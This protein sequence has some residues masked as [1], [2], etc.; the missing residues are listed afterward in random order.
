[1]N[2][3]IVSVYQQFLDALVRGE[4]AF[5]AD[6]ITDLLPKASLEDIYFDLLQPALYEI[7]VLWEK[8]KISIATEH[9]ATAI[10]EGILS[11]VFMQVEVADPHGRTLVIACVA[12]EYHQVGSKM[13]ADYFECHGWRT[14]FVGANTP[15]KALVQS[16]QDLQPD[17]L[18]LSFSINL[19]VDAV[20]STLDQVQANFPDLSVIV[21]GQ[22]LQLVD[23]SIFK[24]YP[25]VTVL[26]SLQSVKDYVAQAVQ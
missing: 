5:C 19:N 6:L 13:I 8:N 12:E 11:Q 4:R 16:L 15:S 18:G 7:G 24:A 2:E 17:L 20:L 26:A 10:V 21:G 3:S 23:E 9:V 14:Y 25:Q 22:G 1:M